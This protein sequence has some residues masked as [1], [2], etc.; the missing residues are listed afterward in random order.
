[1]GFQYNIRKLLLFTYNKTLIVYN[2]TISNINIYKIY[3]I[4]FERK[5]VY[6]VINARYTKLSNKADHSERDD[7]MKVKLDKVILFAAI[8]FTAFHF[9]TAAVS[10]LPGIAQKAVHLLLVLVCFYLIQL[11]D[12][13]GHILKMSI[14][15]LLLLMSIASIGYIIS[16]D[17]TYSLRAGIIYPADIIFGLMLIVCVIEATR[18]SIG[19]TLCIVV[20]VFIAYG[21]LGPYF[22]GALKHSGLSLGKFA[23]LTCLTTDGI[24]GTALYASARYVVLFILLGAI[25]NETGTGR[26]FTDLASSIFGRMKGGPAKIAVVASGFFGS[27]S[28]SAIANVVGTGTFTIPLMK[29]NGF[30]PD[31]AA[32]VEASAST[33]GQIMP[34]VMGAVAF[35]M[36]E[37]MGVSYWTI[38]KAAFIPAVLY[39][40]AILFSVDAY[41]RKKNLVPSE[42]NIPHF[43]DVLKELYLL[44]PLVF[45]I[46]SM[47]VLNWTITKAGVW[48][49]LLTLVITSLKK[50]TRI[51]KERFIRVVKDTLSGSITVGIACAVVGVI[52]AVVMGSGLGFNLSA[53]LIDL[54][55]GKL[56]I[57]LILTMLTSLLL[58]MGMPTTAAYMVLAVLVAPAVVKLGVSKMAAHLFILYFGIIST[59]TP[60]VALAAYAAAGIAEC[61]P[62][63]AGFQG[64][65]LSISGFI[66]PFMFVYNN[67]LLMEGPF[68][69]IITSFLTA[70]VGIFMLSCSLE[71][72]L[73]KWSISIVE[74]LILLVGAVTLIVPGVVSDLIGLACLAAVILFHIV[75]RKRGKA[76]A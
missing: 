41:A 53:I 40:L 5:H 70:I 44:I 13:I 49:I 64:F 27:I 10:V 46:V 33:G 72:Y 59:V 22:P 19:N 15:V 11:K 2:A 20:L 26:C 67:V 52:T 25:M 45:L 8:I 23:T 54:S 48:T 3:T 28:G 60:P 30:A 17:S 42:E 39:F 34:P 18:R 35:V 6:N 71:R 12:H 24:F 43:S 76:A 56:S 57:L 68:L 32:G 36:A 63:R 65:R 74:M 7:A 50:E 1:M 4:V 21:F 58:G 69:E 47:S 29:K 9:Y 73:I 14:D 75:F 55:G 16:I 61:N 66:L 38:V 37:F 51:N 31:F 62:V